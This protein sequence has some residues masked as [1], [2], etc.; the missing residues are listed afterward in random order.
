MAMSDVGVRLEVAGAVATLT[1]HRP[2]HRNALRI[3]DLHRLRELVA[4]VANQ[5][6]QVRV[7]KLAGAG[8]KIF[9]AG[10]E[11]T[12]IHHIN[13]RHNPF[14]AVCD[15][16]ARLPMATVCAVSGGAFGAGADLAMACDFRIGLP[17]ARIRMPAAALGVHYDQTGLERAVAVLGLAG[18]KRMYLAADLIGADD[19][20]RY[21]FLDEVVP[22]E[23]YDALVDE[24]V[25]GLAELAP[26]SVRD[27][28]A[29]LNEVAAGRAD[30]ATIVDRV[31]RNW[32]SED[33][34][35]GA[36]AR[37]ERRP[38]KFTGD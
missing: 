7:V 23:Q 1:L 34:R 8:G 4:E 16:V 37:D 17:E 15:A 32:G 29:S 2:E 9:C 18:A 14:T 21:G 10:L 30:V 6:D 36:V 13:W 19:L 38:A 26:N 28:K 33:F 20:L 31:V 3:S 12:E 24:R 27:L 5:A 25:Q 11:F 35:E 22:A